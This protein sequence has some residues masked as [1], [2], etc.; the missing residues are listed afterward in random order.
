MANLQLQQLGQVA[1]KQAEQI[2]KISMNTVEGFVG[3]QRVASMFCKSDLVPKQF[4]GA[5]NLSN[6]IIAVDMAMRLNMSPL[7]VMQNLYIVY[8]KPGWSSQFLI[9]TFNKLGKYSSIQ[10]K[11]IGEKGKDSWGC[12]AYAK[13]KD[14]GNEIR[15][16]E[17]TIEMSKK[18]GW[19]NKTGSKWQTMPE[20]MLQYRSA[21][22]LIRTHAPEISMG[23]PTQ[24]EV[25]DMQEDE[26]GNYVV[27]DI[28]NAYI[29]PAKLVEEKTEELPEE[30]ANKIQKPRTKKEKAAEPVQEPAPEQAKEEAP[31]QAPAPVQ[32]SAPKEQPAPAPA[33]QQKTEQEIL[34]EDI[35]DVKR[36]LQQEQQAQNKQREEKVIQSNF[37]DDDSFYVNGK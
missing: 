18:E 16:A 19:Y 21:A 6:A 1:Q 23:I 3:L 11:M 32:E 2:V 29:P 22:F 13:E 20:V 26:K 34:A 10:Y 5:E 36:Q 28:T 37:V 31:K 14:T 35:A 7:M 15:G 30:T 12:Y 25:F 9:A 17:V 4:H 27:A 24:E 33:Q 8:N